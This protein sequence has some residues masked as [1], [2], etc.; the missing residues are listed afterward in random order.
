MHA[1]KMTNLTEIRKAAEDGK[2]AFQAAE[3]ETAAGLFAEAARGY[4][5]LGDK[6]NAAE[7]RNNLSVAL[8]KLR[9][10]GEALEA[11]AGTDEIFGGIGDSRRQGM[12]IGNQGSALESLGRLDEALAAYERSAQVLAQAGEGD[13]RSL[14]LQ[15]AAGIQLRRGKVVEAGVR[16]LGALESKQHPSIFERGLRL[17]L[18]LLPH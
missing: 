18:R 8:L 7:L 13:L 10:N 14:V 15:G 9:R 4:E 5:D 16:M 2:A 3:Y 17:L 1:D 6:V 11:V 12:A